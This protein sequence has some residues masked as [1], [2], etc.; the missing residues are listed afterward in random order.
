MQELLNLAE[1]DIHDAAE[2]PRCGGQ[3]LSCTNLESFD[4]FVEL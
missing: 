2:Y 3:V 4:V 1:L